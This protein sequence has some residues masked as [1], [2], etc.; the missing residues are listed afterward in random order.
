M[1]GVQSFA[2]VLRDIRRS[3]SSRRKSKVRRILELQH[4]L[5]NLNPDTE[6]GRIRMRSIHYK[7]CFLE[8]QELAIIDQRKQRRQ[9][10]GMEQ[11]IA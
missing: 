3:A 8:R 2:N 4:R 10:Q 7:I 11:A 9:R 5:E 6:P 1:N